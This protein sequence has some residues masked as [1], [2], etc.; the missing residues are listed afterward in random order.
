MKVLMRFM[1]IADW[2]LLTAYPRHGWNHIAGMG[3][4]ANAFLVVAPRRLSQLLARHP[5]C[6]RGALLAI[7]VRIAI[8]EASQLHES[9]EG[10]LVRLPPRWSRITI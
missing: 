5:D 2:Q 3:L 6:L 1:K 4:L 8:F 10:V 9:A 7:V